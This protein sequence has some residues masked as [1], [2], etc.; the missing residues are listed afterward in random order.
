MNRL[1]VFIPVILLLLSPAYPQSKSELEKQRERYKKQIKENL[2]FY[3]KIKKDKQFNELTI[4]I[5]NDGIRNRQL[6]IDELDRELESLRKQIT[7]EESKIYA[8]ENERIQMQNSLKNIIYSVYKTRRNTSVMML[9]LSSSNINEAYKRIQFFKE[10]KNAYNK[11]FELL[12]QTENQLNRLIT[13]YREKERKKVLL[14]N[15]KQE[16]LIKLQKEKEEKETIL[17]N[18]SKKEKELKA[19]IEANKKLE[20][21]IELKIKEITA[22]E[23][24]AQG[25]KTARINLTPAEKVLS[26]DF[27]ANRGKLPWPV[28]KGIVVGHFGKHEHPVL[29]GIMVNNNGI[30]IATE[31][32][33]EV[34]AVFDGVVTKI[35]LV[36]GGKYVVILRHGNYLTVYQNL[37]EVYVNNG[38][39]V[40]TKQSIGKLID[41]ENKDIVTLHFEI[42]EELSKQNPEEWLSK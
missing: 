4:N 33:G 11:K 32:A 6:L 16:E 30:D 14:I 42:W 7:V 10:L 21:E 18:L 9:I 29:K 3:E 34:R 25:N 13:G 17:K 28:V 2:D 31:N 19:L 5:L 40:K 23:I 27:Q 1:S 20:R 26:K 38:D 41:E 39:K 24:A 12:K 35:F 22:R 15:S 36:K 8:L 37:S